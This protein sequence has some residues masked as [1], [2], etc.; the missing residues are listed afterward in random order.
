MHDRGAGVTRVRIFSCHHTAPSHHY[1]GRLF[2]DLGSNFRDQTGMLSDLDGINIAH[3]NDFSE[4]RHQ[5][6]VWKNLLEQYDH[7][8]FE[9]YRRVMF[10]DPLP[11][12]QMAG[13]DDMVLKMRQIV[14]ATDTWHYPTDADCFDAYINMRDSLS[15]TAIEY[16]R[17][18]IS[19]YDIITVRSC[20]IPV[21]SQWCHGHD[22]EV[23]PVIERCIRTS[24]FFRDR[25]FFVDPQTTQNHLCNI[26]IMSSAI[27]DE[28]MR[29]S[30]EVMFHMRELG[31]RT[32]DRMWG[33]VSERLFSYYLLQSRIARPSL[34]VATLPMLQRR[35]T[36][37]DHPRDRR[38]PVPAF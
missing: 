17:N 14:Q 25:P 18:W 9:H 24:T 29:F 26:Y 21:Q 4:M 28:Y 36:E 37:G 5:F 8:G 38:Q 20:R 16:V 2:Q 11:A 12:E 1:D 31:A 22:P 23:W 27:F 35:D 7:V 13:H 15:D 34:R 32:Q 30:F 33:Y 10:I 6:Y 3:D 19:D